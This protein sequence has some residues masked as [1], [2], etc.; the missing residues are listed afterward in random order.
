MAALAQDTD[1]A[2]T[3]AY[4]GAEP[5]ITNP[6]GL[7]ELRDSF[8]DPIAALHS[9]DLAERLAQAFGYYQHTLVNDEDGLRCIN[10][11]GRGENEASH[12]AE[13]TARI[14]EALTTG[15]PST[16]PTG[17]GTTVPPPGNTPSKRVSS[18]KW[19]TTP[20]GQATKRA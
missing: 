8:G 18:L 13:Y 3:A 6:F 19:T 12:F 1:H 10:T 16:R 7:K 4:S 2:Y 15:I 11:D 17:L 9:P 20:S 14:E 5:N